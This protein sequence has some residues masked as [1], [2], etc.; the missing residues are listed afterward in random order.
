MW[1]E[2]IY[3]NLTSTHRALVCFQREKL[4]YLKNITCINCPLLVMERKVERRMF[5]CGGRIVCVASKD[6]IFVSDGKNHL[7]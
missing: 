1:T 5:F 2:H 7:I 4:S 6:N 3:L